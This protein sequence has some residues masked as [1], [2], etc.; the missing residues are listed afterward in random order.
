MNQKKAEKYI[1]KAL[2]NTLIVTLYDS[3]L[4]VKF[5]D[6]H[7]NSD[8][9]WNDNAK[10]I[11]LLRT[12]VIPYYVL[13]KY[14]GI[15]SE[16]FDLWEAGKWDSI[17]QYVSNQLLIWKTRPLIKKWLLGNHS[18]GFEGNVP[19]VLDHVCVASAIKIYSSDGRL[20]GIIMHGHQA[21]FWNKGTWITN[22]VKGIVHYIWRPINW[23]GG[24]SE[25]KYTS[26]RTNPK[27][28][29]EIERHFVEYGRKCVDITSKPFIVIIGHTHKAALYQ[30]DGC[31]YANS[32]SW[33]HKDIGGECIELTA[34]EITLVRWEANGERVVVKTIAL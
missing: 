12:Y 16:W 34:K 15:I 6:W 14:E 27:R 26:P 24:S 9:N 5:S 19:S 32:G 13:R 22:I 4:Y 1:N 33:T 21:D 31:I 20:I 3:A 30:E 18:L 2:E 25:P 8:G 23:L 7:Q 11:D 29:D 17:W 10:N 28:A